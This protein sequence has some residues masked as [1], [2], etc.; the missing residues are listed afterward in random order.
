MESSKIPATCSSRWK[1]LRR[2][3][4]LSS[5]RINSA[6][7]PSTLNTPS[8]GKK[9]ARTTLL[10]SFAKPKKLS[11]NFTISFSSTNQLRNI[12]NLWTLLFT[13]QWLVFWT[14]SSVSWWNTVTFVRSTQFCTRVPP[15]FSYFWPWSRVSSPHRPMYVS[16]YLELQDP[17]ESWWGVVDLGEYVDRLPKFQEG[18]WGVPDG[19]KELNKHFGDPCAPCEEYVE[20]VIPTVHFQSLR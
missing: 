8:S 6:Q 18:R 1:P 11:P 12:R 2:A 4:S 13:A 14:P 16:F 5:M 17:E 20:T 9:L 10:L 19:F 3:S 7:S 15:S